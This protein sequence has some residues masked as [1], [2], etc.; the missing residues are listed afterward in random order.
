MSESTKRP[1]GKGA[2]AL[3]KRREEKFYALVDKA[4]SLIELAMQ[5]DG[6]EIKDIKQITGALKDLKDLI[7]DK[8]GRN[9]EKSEGM[10]IKIE[11]DVE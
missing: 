7:W 2:K 10:V 1:R 5:E 3:Q 4:Q 8:G 11:G 6:R 9:E